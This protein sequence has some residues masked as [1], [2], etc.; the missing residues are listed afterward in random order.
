MI[1]PG[2]HETLIRSL[3]EGLRPVRPLRSPWLRALGWIVAVGAL[4]SALACFTGLGHVS[5]RIAGGPDGWAELTGAAS[6]AALAAFAAFLLS[7]PDRT[8][9]WALLPV[10]PLVIW[11]LA[12]GWGCWQTEQA[13]TELVDAHP[14]PS[15]FAFI[16]GVSV[17][18]SVLLF[19]MLRR[20]YPVR[21]DLTATMGGLAAAGA[22][23]TLLEF[24]HPFDITAPD[25]LAHMGAVLLVVGANRVASGR[26]FRA[27]S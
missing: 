6:T 11:V 16:V 13:G 8:P 7:I 5:R 15:C 3:A 10:P 22:S 23:A 2:G 1:E 21:P 26:A 19:L 4:A 17:P 9:A 12:S 18:L 25:L 27:A 20:A 24:F 14:P